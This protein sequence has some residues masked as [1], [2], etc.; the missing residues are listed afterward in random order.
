ME[1]RHVVF[2]CGGA[3]AGSEAAARAV[4]RGATVVVL[5]QND[6]PYGKIEDGLPRWHGA[7]QR[8][9]RERIDASLGLPGVIYVPR[10][11]LGRD[12]DYRA[13]VDELRPSL[14]LLANGAWRD[15]PLAPWAD[16]R[17]VGH[18]LAYQ[19]PFVQWFNHHEEPGYDGPEQPIPEG[20]LVIGGGLA[21]I[22]VAKILNLELY[23]AALR[24][25]GLEADVLEMERA[26]I[27]KALSAHGLT[28]EDLELRGCTLYYRRRLEDMPLATADDPTPEQLE[29]LQRTRLKILDKVCQRYLVELTPLAAAK[30]PLLDG[31]R[32]AG[33]VFQRTRLQGGRV[34]SIEGSDFEVP[35]DLVVSAIGS[36][37]V[38]IPGIQTRGE[39]YAFQ[40]LTTGVLETGEVPVVGLGNVLT[41][42]G[43][44]SGSLK[45]AREVTERVMA[46][47]L[48][49]ESSDAD[50]DADALTEASHARSAAVADEAL[51]LLRGRAPLPADRVAALLGWAGRRQDEVGYDGDYAGWITRSGGLGAAG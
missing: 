4:E 26:G 20:A 22:D 17:W 7:L 5:E 46:Y 24:A 38:P 30:A 14:V 25:R 43:N 31:G 8:K 11:E 51:E 15:R 21:S 28:P 19:N 18:G 9:Q 1:A 49:R 44:I 16:D 33:L 2:I 12:L 45:S 39:L 48:D 23:A 34:H 50:P 42:R 40:D 10:T 29:R 41:G 27:P 3:V 47:L 35:S 32:L 37:P 36:L 6:R 13:L